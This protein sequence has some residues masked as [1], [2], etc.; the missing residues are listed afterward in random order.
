M[1]GWEERT[2]ELSAE[3]H[4]DDGHIVMRQSVAGVLMQRLKHGRL[5]LRQRRA[6]VGVEH[7]AEP[8]GTEQLPRGVRGLRDTVGIGKH[9]PPSHDDE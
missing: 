9:L 2:S 7:L 8:P 4:G 3:L 5:Q 1:Q 6:R